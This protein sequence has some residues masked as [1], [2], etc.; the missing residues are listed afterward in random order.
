MSKITKFKT[1][2]IL[3]LF[4]LFILCFINALDAHIL[5]IGDSN[6]DF[7]T[8]YQET[9]QLANDLKQRGY[10]VLELYRENATSE[11]ILKGMYDADAVIYAGHGGYQSG[12][13]DMNGGIAKVPFALV[14]SDDF[15]W[16]IGNQMR[17]GWSSNLF[18]APFKPGIP[19]FF[20]H[21]CFS[22]GWVEDK[23]VANPIETI[24][25]FAT[26]F[27]GAGA[28]Y[29]ATAW[30]GAEIIYDFLNGASNFQQANNQNYEKITLSTLYNGT[31]IWR[32]N[33]GY[34]AF[35]GNWSGTFPLA[36]QTTAY[37][38]TAAEI[39]YN[40]NRQRNDLNALFFVNAT[41]YNLNQTVKF[42][43]AS[44]NFGGLIQS[45]IWDFGDG[46][47]YTS[48]TAVNITHNYTVP[49]RYTVKHTVTDNQNRSDIYTETISIIGNQTVRYVNALLGNDSWDGSSPTWISGNIGPI[50]TIQ[51]AVNAVANSG[52][53]NVA[54]GNYT[55]NIVLNKKVV[56]TAQGDVTVKAN[57]ANSPVLT[58]G[59]LGS[60]STVQGFILTGSTDSGIYMDN[61]TQNNI[62]NNTIKGELNT[63]N[64]AWGICIVNSNGPNNITNN[65]VINC[66]EGINLYNSNR[67]LISNNIVKDSVWDNIALTMSTGNIIIENSVNNSDSGIRLI[68]GSN[69]N[70]ITNNNLNKNI[71][72]SISLVYSENNKIGLN[73]LSECQEGMYLY[74]SNDNLIYN[75]T[76][77]N[78]IWDGFAIH[79]S[80]NNTLINNTQVST[81]NCGIYLVSGSTSNQIHNNTLNDNLWAGI[82]LKQSNGNNISGNIIKSNLVG[83]HLY[84]YASNNY[85]SKNNITNNNWDGVDIL[86][87]SNNNTIVQNNVTNR[88]YGVRILNSTQNT[89]YKNNFNNNTIQGF[90][91]NN[92]QW[93]KNN[94]GN[95][96]SDWNN[97]NPRPIDGGLNVDNHPSL[98]PF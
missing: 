19:V 60:G 9:T 61:S 2:S 6:S 55:E 62:K 91:D 23:Q 24:Y 20:L 72:T 7:P 48:N 8:A 29:Y 56:L 79:S 66:A 57:A 73:N 12:N 53:I 67:T 75:N 25:N 82:G 59:T 87:G 63:G 14:G 13:Y 35:V 17:E 37:N 30:N 97:S 40:S 70:T 84:Q 78:N 74:T 39:W 52:T 45:Y 88:Y 81:N 31:Q 65:T 96:W 11:N 16:G 34:A 94:I 80:N 86:E 95:Y 98:E 27:T 85:I 92:N 46:T 51:S 1:A 44:Y 22:T 38:D 32:N 58:I 36:F 28:N 77:K 3:F 18:K 68:S 54:S 43:E 93:D 50:K 47:V 90:S 41:T 21:A 89:V 33:N 69:N 83:V 15:I 5:I 49:G 71:W 10:D 64:M 4:F 76:A 42:F 26:M